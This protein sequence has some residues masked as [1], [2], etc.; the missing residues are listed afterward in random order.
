MYSTTDV[1]AATVN[2]TNLNSTLAITQFYPGMAIDPAKSDLAIGGTQDNGTQRFTGADSWNNVTCGDGGF[3]TLDPSNAA[4]AYG[5]CQYIA[6]QRINNVSGTAA[7]TP[8][9]YGINSED[10]ANTAFISP[11][12]IDPANTTTLYFGTYRLWQSRD[13][14]GRWNAITPDLTGGKRGTIRA[15]TVAPSDSN[16]VYAGTSNGKLFSATDAQNGAAA[17]WTDRSA[18]LSSRV[19]THIAV[20]PVD[21]ATAYVTFSGF[22]P[23]LVSTADVPGHIFK[24]TDYGAHWTHADGNLANIPVNDLVIDPDL[25]NTLYIATDA[26]VMVT[27][28]GGA[29]WSSLGQSLPRVVV[30]SLTLHR[31]SRTLRAATHGRSVW[32]ILV[33][34]S[35]HSLGAHHRFHCARLHQLRRPDLYAYGHRLQLRTGQ[36]T[37]LEWAEPSH[38]GGRRRAPHRQDSGHFH[39][40]ARQGFRIGVQ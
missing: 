24:T 38:H 14:A 9:I 6:V 25:P 5:S 19:I 33:P 11:L 40:P 16:V 26:G 1:K 4:V 2:W 10:A 32:D 18:G 23:A 29:N 8:A 22:T 21:S 35:G 31:L 39:C 27:L 7:W 12:T 13:S 15:V 37:P 34:L 3:Q 20:D 36:R 17:N 28:D 30:S